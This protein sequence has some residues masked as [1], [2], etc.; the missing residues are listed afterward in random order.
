MVL[1]LR[2]MPQIDLKPRQHSSSYE[3]KPMS[4]W[5][6]AVVI[7]AILLGTSVNGFFDWVSWSLIGIGM[8]AGFAVILVF[9][10]TWLSRLD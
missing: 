8:M 2:A 4:R 6:L 3:I 9:P 10:R 1:I 7:G 5:W